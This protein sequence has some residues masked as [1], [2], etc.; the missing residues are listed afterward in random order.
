MEEDVC[1][2]ADGKGRAV[3]PGLEA[4][5][6]EEEVKRLPVVEDLVAVRHRAPDPRRHPKAHQDLA[7]SQ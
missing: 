1:V 7:P 4:P 5:A 6:V 2:G 3:L